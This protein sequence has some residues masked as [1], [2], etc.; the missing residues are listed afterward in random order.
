M[1]GYLKK[2]PKE[3]QDLILLAGDIASINNMRAYLVGGCVRDLLLKVEN[4]D[5]DIVI[6]GNGIKF[7]EELAGAFNTKPIRHRRFGT[8]TVDLLSHRLK[9][10]IAT[11]RKEFYPEPAHLPVVENGSLKDD[12]KRRDF[13]INAM[14]ININRDGFGKL[15][16]LFGGEED[17]NNRKIRVL[18]DLSFIDD[19][20]RILRGIRFEQRYNFRFEPKT[21][22][23]LKEA[24]ALRMLERVEPQRIRD[25]LI[26]LLKENY[27]LKEIRRLKEL[28]GFAFISPG[29]SVSD[30]IFRLI[31]FAEKQIN[32]FK[33]NYPDRRMLDTWAIY[34]MAL[35]DPLNSNAVRKVCRKFVFR[36]GEDKRILGY[37][38][39][40]RKFISNLKRIKNKPPDIFSILEPLSYEVILLVKAKYKYRGIQ[41]TIEDFLEIY[42]GMKIC[43]KGDDLRRLG[44]TPGPSYQ[45]I[46]TKVLNAKLNGAVKTKEEELEL[47]K[48]LIRK[49]S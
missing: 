48:K 13:T 19:P 25:D 6:E 42:N 28:V 18:H 21:K 46:F 12:L 49:W 2:L 14:A 31:K 27:P 7:A 35:M 41:K 20:T 33:K 39:I 24:V 40:G 8:A 37:K 29:L 44:L 34:F 23:L 36:K 30:K 22:K 15:L 9:I 1:K 3:V 17:L 32:W 10:D 45:E 47:I 26:L 5:L 43:S 11:A 16:D 4:L 38:K